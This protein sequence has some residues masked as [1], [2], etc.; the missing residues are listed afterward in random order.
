[1]TGEPLNWAPRRPGDR[2]GLRRRKPVDPVA[3]HRLVHELIHASL[4]TLTR[5]ARKGVLCRTARITSRCS[6]ATSG[7]CLR[8]Q[9]SVVVNRRQLV[10]RSRHARGSIGRSAVR[11]LSAGG[12]SSVPA[13]V[14]TPA[15]GADDNS[16]NA[17]CVSARRNFLLTRGARRAVVIRDGGGTR[18]L[19][20]LIGVWVVGVCVWVRVFGWRR[21]RGLV[22][23]AVC[24]P[25]G[26][27]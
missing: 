8:P 20:T 24:R 14:P 27:G 26:T 9:A 13:T 6:T 25:C 10:D 19:V 1:M 18:R 16:A 7:G 11:H 17:I 23:A 12:S 22:G 2:S 21:V 4:E 15:S 5:W 3:A